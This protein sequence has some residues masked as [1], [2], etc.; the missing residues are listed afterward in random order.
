MARA[1]PAQRI[2]LLS[3]VH[4]VEVSFGTERCDMTLAADGPAP[5]D[6]AAVQETPGPG[7]CVRHRRCPVAFH[8]PGKSEQPSRTTHDHA[9]K[10]TDVRRI[11][12]ATFRGR[13]ALETA[14]GRQRRGRA[15]RPRAGC[16]RRGAF[17]A[18]SSAVGVFGQSG[19]GKSTLA[20]LIAGLEAADRGTIEIG[21][22][23]V[24]APH[25][26][27]CGPCGARSRSCSS[28]RTPRW[29]R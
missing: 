29:T 21:A 8:H 19:S 23:P 25:D 12:L 22:E 10:L 14:G 28:I 3:R 18:R 1:V 13:H 7:G 24:A 20:R 2:R 5:G 4:R 27:A 17:G 15:G 6:G 26:R 11:A 16:A 9:M